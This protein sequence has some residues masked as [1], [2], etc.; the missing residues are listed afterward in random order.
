MFKTGFASR[1]LLIAAFFASLLGAKLGLAADFW[2]YEWLATPSINGI[3]GGDRENGNITTRHDRPT[4]GDRRWVVTEFEADPYRE[5]LKALQKLPGVDRI[6]VLFKRPAA[7]NLADDYVALARAWK[8]AGLE[9][10]FKFIGTLPTKL[11]ASLLRPV[12]DLGVSV[13][14]VTNFLPGDEGAESLNSLRGCAR[15]DFSIGRYFKYDEVKVIKKIN[16]V[17]VSLTNNF[18]P[19][20]S[21]IDNLNLIGAPVEVRVQDAFPMQSHVDY[22]NAI[23]KLT[24]VFIDLD[25]SP[26][27][28]QYT[29]LEKID[30]S[31]GKRLALRFSW[32]APR[33]T[34]FAALARIKPNRVQV[35]GEHLRTAGVEQ[36]LRALDTEVIVENFSI[37]ERAFKPEYYSNP[38]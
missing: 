25:M 30:R 4:S 21:Q 17:P 38:R 37:N 35:L 5:Q 6:S 2:S 32:A 13:F 7:A 12:C 29:V 16:A 31:G 33:D 3:T 9:G 27:E 15:V 19:G 34:D 22:L 26:N 14:F 36:K 23:Q 8:T 10:Q 1:L 11:E 18:F 20:Y 28:E 24:G